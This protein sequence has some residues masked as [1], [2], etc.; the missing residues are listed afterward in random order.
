VL[1]MGAVFA[2]FAGWYYWIGKIT[3]ANYPEALG[4]IHF[5]ST[6]IGVNV[7]FFPMHFLGLAGMPR[8]IPDFPDAYNQWNGIASVGSIITMVS[9]VFFLYVIFA[10]FTENKRV[11]YSTWRNYTNFDF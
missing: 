9:T 5:W 8:R 2:I 3:G 7:C 6:F 11:G 1:S 10:T 4:K